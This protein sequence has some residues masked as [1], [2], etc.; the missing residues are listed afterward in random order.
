MCAGSAFLRTSVL[1]KMRGIVTAAVAAFAL[2]AADAASAQSDLQSVTVEGRRERATLERRVKTFVSS[3]TTTP[4]QE[5]LAQWQKEIPICP[6]VSGL[7]YEDGEF[8]LA[9]FS[10]IARD[11][12]ASLAGEVCSV[13]LR[14]VVTSV[15]DELAAEW[16]KS[17][18]AMFGDASTSKLRQFFHANTPVRVWYNTSLFTGNGLPCRVILND[19]LPYCEQDAETAQVRIAALRDFFSVIVVV[20]ANKIKGISMGQLAAYISMVGL[21]EIRIDAKLGDAPTILRLFTDPANAP[22]LGLSTWDEAYLKALY[23]TQ[24]EDRTQLLAI[25]TSIIKEVTQPPA[26]SGDR[27]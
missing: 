23:H 26:G 2:L 18:P 12:G 17:S 22:P 24:H 27:K 14:V 6:E 13:N 4:Y 16:G 9:R 7:P 1:L 19:A 10:Q 8:V 5:S 21:A 20:D 15:P 25:K 3:I 11:A